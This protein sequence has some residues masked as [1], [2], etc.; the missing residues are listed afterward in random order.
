MKR[1]LILGTFVVGLIGS[2]CIVCAE[3]SKVQR[4]A[5]QIMLRVVRAESVGPVKIGSDPKT[6][7]PT[8]GAPRVHETIKNTLYWDSLG[9]MAVLDEHGKVKL[10]RVTLTA[11]DASPSGVVLPLGLS[12]AATVQ[13][14]EDAYAKK[15]VESRGLIITS[16]TKEIGNAEISGKLVPFVSIAFPGIKYSWQDG[17]LQYVDVMAE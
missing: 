7:T 3:E 15:P 12:K 6:A 13:Q 1:M 8:L 14:V 5:A 9:L 4:Q 2:I 10:I 16:G 17:K 11:Q